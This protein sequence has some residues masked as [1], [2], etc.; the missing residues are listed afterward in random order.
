MQSLSAISHLVPASIWLCGISWRAWPSGT[1]SAYSS[2][3][4]AATGLRA[5][6]RM[7]SSHRLIASYKFRI[8]F[9]DAYYLKPV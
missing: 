9:D 2:S 1:R 8:A 5:G 7:P 6:L 4:L 3:I